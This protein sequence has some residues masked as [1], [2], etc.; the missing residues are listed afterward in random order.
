LKTSKNASEQQQT[1]SFIIRRG[2]DWIGAADH[3]IHA[4][5]VQVHAVSKQASERNHNQGIKKVPSSE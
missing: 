3:R 4:V 5:T 1:R 2:A